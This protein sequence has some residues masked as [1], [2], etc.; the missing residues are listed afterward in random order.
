MG[1]KFMKSFKK[2]ETKKSLLSV[3]KKNRCIWL[4][5]ILKV[6]R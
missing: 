5:E 1:Q 6:N 4:S 2:K 3:K